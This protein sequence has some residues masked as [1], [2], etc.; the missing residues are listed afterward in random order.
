MRLFKQLL[1]AG[2]AALPMLAMAHAGH[3]HLMDSGL[4]LSILYRFRSPDDGN[5]FW[6]IDV[7]YKS[8]LENHG[9]HRSGSSDG[10][11]LCAR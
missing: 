11:R 6:C 5:C 8:A 2:I 9:S 3:D 1:V 7:D 10:C 4:A